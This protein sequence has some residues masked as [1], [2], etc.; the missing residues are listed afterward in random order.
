MINMVINNRDI[1]KVKQSLKNAGILLECV[2]LKR[3]GGMTNRSYMVALKDGDGLYEVV[4]RIPGEGT[5]EIINR[6]DE[7]KSTELACRLDIDSKL[8][9]FGD[10]GTKIME[11]VHEPQYM[12]EFMMQQSEIIYKA[13]DIFRRLH[14]SGV[15]TGVR[16]DFISMAGLYESVIQKNGISLY[17]D[18]NQIK[19]GVLDI[20]KEIESIKGKCTVPCHNDSL[21]G[22]WVLGGDGR[23]YLIDWEYSGMNDP[24][25]DLSCLSIE[26]S[27]SDKHDMELLNAYYKKDISDEEILYFNASKLYVDYLWTLWG[28]TRVSHDGESMMDYANNRYNRLRTNMKK[29]YDMISQ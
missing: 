26:A 12:N 15:D 6:E 27:Y 14:H 29:C 20:K 11:Y 25:W 17:D 7:R 22:N 10:D 24:M 3:L 2:S 18:Y 23:L 1:I 4:V 5:E 16:F 21:L 19:Q 13:A 9:Y 8:L 28:L